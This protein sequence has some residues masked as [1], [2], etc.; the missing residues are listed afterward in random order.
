[1]VPS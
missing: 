1:M